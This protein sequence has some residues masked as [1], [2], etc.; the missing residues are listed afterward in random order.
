[1][2]SAAGGTHCCVLVNMELGR[3]LEIQ[4][5]DLY[6]QGGVEDGWCCDTEPS[7]CDGPS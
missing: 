2:L 5:D 1:M 4:V 6:D 3:P 7:S